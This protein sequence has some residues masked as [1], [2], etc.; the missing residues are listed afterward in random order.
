[1]YPWQVV[2][3][4]VLLLQLANILFDEFIIA[5]YLRFLCLI[6]NKIK[7]TPN[8]FGF[9]VTHPSQ[10]YHNNNIISWPIYRVIYKIF[11]RTVCYYFFSTLST[12]F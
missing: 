4:L 9:A 7:S 2:L 11:L 3:I 6:D 5:D 8:C 1:M 10:K 12:T